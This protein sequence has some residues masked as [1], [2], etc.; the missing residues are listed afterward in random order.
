M[1]N[2]L[3]EC[4]FGVEFDFEDMVGSIEIN[5]RFYL[6]GFI[7]NYNGNRDKLDEFRRL[8][9]K[10]DGDFLR[11]VGVGVGVWGSVFVVLL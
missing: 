3:E 6:N 7:Y 11:I 1:F 4:V 9:G 10:V 8:L 2:L 5:C